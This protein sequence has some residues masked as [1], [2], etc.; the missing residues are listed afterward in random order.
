MV[1]QREIRIFTVVTLAAVV[2]LAGSA[3]LAERE[4]DNVRA[5][6]DEANKNYEQAYRNKDAA[7]IADLY[8]ED[9]QLYPPMRT[10]LEG[11]GEI[12]E[13]IEDQMSMGIERIKLRI[14]EVHASEVGKQEVSRAM[15]LGQ[16]V[17]AGTD[18]TEQP[19]G[20]CRDQS[21]Q[22]VLDGEAVRWGE[23][24]PLKSKEIDV[25]CGFLGCDFVASSDYIE[26]LTGV[27]CEAGPAERFHVRPA[28][29]CCDGELE[30]KPVALLD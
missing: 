25:G 18:D 26:N 11:P 20:L 13:A 24:Q 17:G 9:A 19:G 10:R 12:Q 3:A 1:R 2:L 7:A 8:L 30:T 21:V 6:I 4:S 16:G 29:G 23:F 14:L 15:I 22:R 28:G 5:V 27:L